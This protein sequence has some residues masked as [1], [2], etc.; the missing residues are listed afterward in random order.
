MDVEIIVRKLPHHFILL[1][2]LIYL[3]SLII[4]YLSIHLGIHNIGFRDLFA[5]KKGT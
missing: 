4:Y 1:E 2:R 5:K 3:S